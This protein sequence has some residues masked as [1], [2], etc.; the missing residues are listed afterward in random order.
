MNNSIYYDATI[1]DDERRAKI[2]AGQIFVYSPRPSSLAYCEFARKLA[3]EALAPHDPRDAQHRLDVDR[4][5]TILNEFKPKFIHHP[6]SKRHVQAILSEL[7]CSPEETYFDVPRIRTSTSNGYLTTG[8]AYAW[9]PH[10]DT[11][12][13]APP[14]QVNW[15]IP[16]YEITADNAMAFHPKY[17]T[18]GIPNDSIH[19]D[20]GKWATQHRGAHLTK[21]T[22]AD[23][24]PLSK[25]LEAI[26]PNPQIRLIVPTGGI[27]MF[28]GAQLH[29]SVPNTSGVTRFSID[30]RSV[31]RGDAAAR[32]GAVNVDSNSTGTNLRDFMRTS[33]LARLPQE[34]VQLYDVETTETVA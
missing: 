11:W 29:S 6:E 15:W 19:H 2:Y 4:Y 21:F 24:R 25:P 22:K 26:D 34:V 12:Y 9:H 20:Y 31:H 32:R 23:P 8:I 3:E 7:G 5:A 30:F 27:I 16:V 13:S 18:Q 14:C 10:R 17:F 33:D 28:S 1:P